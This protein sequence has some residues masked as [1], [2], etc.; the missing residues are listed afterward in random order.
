MDMNGCMK[1]IR[2]DTYVPATCQSR[3]WTY[4][5]SH[6]ITTAHVPQSIYQLE[7]L[8]RRVHGFMRL[9]SHPCTSISSIQLE[10]RLVR[11]GNVFPVIHS[12]ISV[13]TSPDEA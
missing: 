12:P 5:R 13:L 3:I 11:P 10:T 2:Q 7:L 8:T 1:V 9:S 6:I 4:Q